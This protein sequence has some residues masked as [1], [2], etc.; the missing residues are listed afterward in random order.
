L[1]KNQ[2]WYSSLVSIFV[3]PVK[4]SPTVV[5]DENVQPGKCYPL[6][7]GGMI[8]ISLPQPILV[9]DITID[10]IHPLLSKGENIPKEFTIWGWEAN[11]GNLENKK[12]LLRS[13][14]PEGK[15]LS[16]FQIPFPEVYQFI[17]F[18]LVSSQ[19]ETEFTC[20]YRIRIHSESESE[21]ESK[22]KSSF[23]RAGFGCG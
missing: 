14:F 6:Q 13:N 8:T 15:Q 2:N 20:I 19:K 22:S 7:N 4:I 18:E 11:N 1:K 12:E 16:T 5:L 23:S 3:A 9:T 21:S 17:S 10:V